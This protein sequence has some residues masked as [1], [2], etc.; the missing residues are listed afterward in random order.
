MANG[1]PLPSEGRLINTAQ[2]IDP[3]GNVNDVFVI[4]YLGTPSTGRAALICVNLAALLA[5][6][7]TTVQTA[8]EAVTAG[9]GAVPQVLAPEQAPAVPMAATAAAA[10]PAE[11]RVSVQELFDELHEF[12]LAHFRYLLETADGKLQARCV[13]QTQPYAKVSQQA[14]FDVDPL[15]VGKKTYYLLDTG[16]SLDDVAAETVQLTVDAAVPV[17]VSMQI[18][19]PTHTVGVVLPTTECAVNVSCM[20]PLVDGKVIVK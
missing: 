9:N 7:G 15:P 4:G 16:L 10:A 20:L 5:A 8:R 11:M 1:T 3:T 13:G 2:E 6:R 19:E 14:A 18:I 17:P 12:K